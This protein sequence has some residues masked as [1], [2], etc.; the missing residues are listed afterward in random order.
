M[1]SKRDYK[2]L[3]NSCLKICFALLVKVETYFYA[4]A[5]YSKTKQLKRKIRPSGCDRGLSQTYFKSAAVPILNDPLL[6][7]TI[8]IHINGSINERKLCIYYYQSQCDTETTR[9]SH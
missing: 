8:R 1:F 6:S 2:T 3:N 9:V 7:S 5:L 4:L